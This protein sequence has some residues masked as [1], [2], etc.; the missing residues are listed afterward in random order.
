MKLLRIAAGHR[1]RVRLEVLWWL[2]TEK[3]QRGEASDLFS[4]VCPVSVAP[5]LRLRWLAP[6]DCDILDR[7]VACCRNR[8]AS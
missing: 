3:Q 2:V 7:V 1:E 6:A 5:M 4:A 8:S